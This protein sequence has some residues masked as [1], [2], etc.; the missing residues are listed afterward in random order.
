MARQRSVYDEEIKLLEKFRGNPKLNREYAEWRRKW[1]LA[2][3]VRFAHEIL[4]IDP[5]TGK[6]LQLSGDQIEFL[7]DLSSGKIRLAIVI[8]GRGAGKTFVLAVYVMW[9]IFTHESWHIA[10]MG[11]SK[12]Q[13]DKIHSFITGWI[14]NS[15]DLRKY[16]LKLIEKEVKSLANGSATFHACSGTSIRG[17]HTHDI[18]IDEEASGEEAGGTKFIRAAIWDVSTSPDIHIIK[19][20]TAH[21][22]HGDFIQ[23]WNNSEKLGYKRY[24]WAI[25]KHISGEKDPYK[26]FNDM[27]PKNWKSNVPWIPEMNIPIL[28]NDKS[29]DEWLVEALGGISISSG[30]VFNPN[31]ID[32]CI[33][34]LCPDHNMQCLPYK[35]GHCVIIQMMLEL[36]GAPKEMIPESTR[37]AL[38]EFVK[39]RV[40][41]IDWGDVSPCAYTVVGRLRKLA[42]VLFSNELLGQT[43]SEK[44]NFATNLARNLIVENVRPDPREWAY[45]NALRDAGLAVHTLFNIEGGR[46]KTQYVYNIKKYIERH[47]LI[48][49]CAF[50]DLIRS[51]KQLSYDENGSIR[52]QDDHSFDSLLYAMSYYGEV[53][54][55]S[56]FWSA[57]QKM[58][59][60][61][62]Y[63]IPEGDVKRETKPKSKEEETADPWEKIWGGFDLWGSKSK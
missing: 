18:I 62:T 61:Q 35:E 17:P 41:G 11:G 42:F 43:D 30:L 38:M 24:R 36:L 16:K 26:V 58:T 23:T 7:E 29:N 63:E 19:S 9:R 4:Q 44:I 32:S 31:D 12:D 46:D 51:L 2:G 56:P 21:F 6:P 54:E 22:V 28:R 13:S 53:V 48:I 34:T 27:N 5:S 50:E 33:C 14:Q 57:M 45:N 37:K 10:C 47:L 59:D 25:A 20:S 39:E 55:Q 52:K 60:T 49:P 1:R 3:P 15:D 40:E 8:A